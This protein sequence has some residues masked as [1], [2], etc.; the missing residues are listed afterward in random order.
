M[1]RSSSKGDIFA[2][3]RVAGMKIVL[4]HLAKALGLFAL[5]RWLTRRGLRILCYH[6]IWL[7]DGHFG[8]FL[9]MSPDKFAA[10]MAFLAGAGYPML[11]LEDAVAGL[12]DGSLPPGATAIT[13]DDGWHGTHRHMLPALE[14]HGLPATIYVTTYFV[15]RQYPVFDL[16]VGYL[17]DR[18]GAQKLDLQT[19]DIPG[20]GRFA[21][22]HP[23]QR[24]KAADAILLHGRERLNGAGRQAFGARL[25]S[26]LGLDYDALVR[27]KVFHL[28]SFAEIA[29]AVER[30]HDIQLH[31]HRH[32]LPLDDSAAVEREIEE[33]RALLEPI[34]K[35]PL[36]HFCYPS[37]IYVKQLWPR[38]EALNIASATTIEQG[39]NFPGTP[40]LGL[41]RL[42]DGQEVH[43]IELEAELSGF[44][45]LTRRLGRL[46]KPD[47]VRRPTTEGTEI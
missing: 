2:N 21:L 31:T 3:D 30:G 15:Q 45:E 34:A 22:V 4:F 7:G 38:L 46:F 35:K 39:L 25:G 43:Q 42:L 40:L 33:N 9:F 37:G 13:I 10:R 47:A 6:G 5:S 28:M 12:R 11:T 23:D 44:V 41:K 16:V 20:G 18:A 32:R 26:I 1:T 8:N 17:L 36:R 29:D 27:E 19:L 14:A 24:R